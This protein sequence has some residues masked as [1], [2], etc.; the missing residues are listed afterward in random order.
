MSRLAGGGLI[1]LLILAAPV[2]VSAKVIEVPRNVLR[3]DQALVL[4]HT[5]DT[6]RVDPGRYFGPFHLPSGVRLESSR[7]AGATVLAAAN[8]PSVIR[9]SGGGPGTAVIGFTIEGGLV[10]VD[11]EGGVLELTRC[12]VSGADS[13]GLRCRPGSH[14]RVLA[15]DFRALELAV[16]AE[17]GADV[18]LLNCLFGGNSIGVIVS[19]EDTRIL[20]CRF[21]VNGTAVQVTP[22]GS[23][24]VGG[25]L[26]EGNDFIENVVAL[27]NQGKSPV[28]AEANYWGTVHCDS[29]RARLRGP[30][31]FLPAAARTHSDTLDICR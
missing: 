31:N 2:A 14:A 23:A 11:L 19:A 25:T 17:P 22:L 26:R 9:S 6:V 29:L 15:T 3:L 1:A 21:E 30:V 7:G 18:L 13:L 12:R 20:R 28:S 10:A 4:A 27:D 16:S 5:G 8:T 24:R